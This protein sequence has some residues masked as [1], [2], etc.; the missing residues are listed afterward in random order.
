M[1]AGLVFLE[2][3]GIASVN[4]T[5]VQAFAT[6]AEA[7]A[8]GGPPPFVMEFLSIL[9]ATGGFSVGAVVGFKKG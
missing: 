7:A 6:T 5:K 8:S 4:W 2:Q 1:V 3:Q 9:P